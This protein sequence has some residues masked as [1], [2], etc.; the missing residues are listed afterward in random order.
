MLEHDVVLAT[1]DAH[2]RELLACLF[3]VMHPDAVNARGERRAADEP[4]RRCL[5]RWCFRRQAWGSSAQIRRDIPDSDASSPQTNGV[6][7]SGSYAS[8]SACAILGR[9]L[10]S[11]GRLDSDALPDDGPGAGCSAAR[12]YGTLIGPE[13]RVVQDATSKQ[14]ARPRRS[15]LSSAGSDGLPQPQQTKKQQETGAA[16]DFPP[17]P[18][19]RTPGPVVPSSDV[20]GAS[21]G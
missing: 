14:L 11:A 15:S 18:H 20:W 5:R 19:T 6:G 9:D 7:N 10:R 17:T 2:G 12:N 21:D 13:P 16:Y 1:L 8:A 3:H 4:F